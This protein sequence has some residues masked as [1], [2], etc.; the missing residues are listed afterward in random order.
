RENP[1][2]FCG[3]RAW[4]R[5]FAWDGPDILHA[6]CVLG[7]VDEEQFAQVLADFVWQHRHQLSKLI[8][9]QQ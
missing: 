6:E 2:G 3:N 9:K 1:T 5:H 8:N 4:M 7:D